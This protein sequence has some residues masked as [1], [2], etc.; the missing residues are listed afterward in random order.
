MCSLILPFTHH[1]YLLS[2]IYPIGQQSSEDLKTKEVRNEAAGLSPPQQSNILATPQASNVSMAE[3]PKPQ[4]DATPKT[5]PVSKAESFSTPRSTLASEELVDLHRKLIEKEKAVV[6]LE[7]KLAT[8]KQ[9]RV[10]DKSKLK[11]FEKLKMQNQQ[12]C[13]FS[14]SVKMYFYSL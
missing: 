4:P 9:K 8:L 5:E 1:S 13:Y 6:D 11:E 10:E 12:V 2:L 3:T 7:E 14:L